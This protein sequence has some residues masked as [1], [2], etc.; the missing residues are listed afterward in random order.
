MWAAVHIRVLALVAEAD[1]SVYL[2]ILNH[3]LLRVPSV[4]KP[5]VLQQTFLVGTGASIPVSRSIGSVRYEIT[6]D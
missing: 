3:H 6:R 2:T 5:P 1:K 4:V